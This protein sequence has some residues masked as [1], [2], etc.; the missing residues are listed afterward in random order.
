MRDFVDGEVFADVSR[1]GFPHEGAFRVVE[2]GEKGAVALGGPE[3]GPI[4]NRLMETSG[5]WVYLRWGEGEP[6]GGHALTMNY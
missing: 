5:G 6:E 3:G 2:F 1:R 4:G